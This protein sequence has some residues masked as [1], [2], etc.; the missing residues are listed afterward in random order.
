MTLTS[1]ARMIYQLTAGVS[2]CPTHM[3]PLKSPQCVCEIHNEKT[4]RLGVCPNQLSWYLTWI[5]SAHQVATGHSMLKPNSLLL[6]SPIVI[7]S[8]HPAIPRPWTCSHPS[9]RSSD[10]LG[11]LKKSKNWARNPWISPWVPLTLGGKVARCGN[12]ALVFRVFLSR[13]AMSQL[14]HLQGT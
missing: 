2:Q 13:P 8:G 3:P 4:Y 11:R 12:P 9:T 7:A 5:G 6:K 10:L 1:T 14:C